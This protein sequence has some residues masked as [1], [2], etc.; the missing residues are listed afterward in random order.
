MVKKS[1]DFIG[2]R[3][4]TRADTARTDRKQLV[5]L[6]TDDPGIVLME[7]AHVIATSAERAPPV[8]ML[9][10]VT[11]SYFSPNPDRSIAMALVKNG[12]ARM[13]EQLF[14]S[15]RDGAP[16]PVKVSGTDFLAEGAADG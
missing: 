7:G 12:R 15:R 14:V 5:G 9:G 8:P 4:L 6:L 11:S 16:I 1:G 2:R 13:G 10:H 3:S